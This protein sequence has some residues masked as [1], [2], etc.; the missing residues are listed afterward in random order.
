VLTTSHGGLVTIGGVFAITTHGIA[1]ADGDLA[2]EGL[3]AGGND[4]VRSSA[5]EDS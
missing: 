5:S 1:R 3:L 2:E 4:P